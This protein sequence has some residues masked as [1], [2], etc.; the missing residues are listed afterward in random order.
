MEK[1]GEKGYLGNFGQV[2]ASLGKL[3]QVWTR[4]QIK[5]MGIKVERLRKEK[6]CATCAC[7]TFVILD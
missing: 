6:K 5:K 3:G 4:Q 2:W 1:G 7:A